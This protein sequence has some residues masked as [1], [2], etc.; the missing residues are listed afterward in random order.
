M[1]S[2]TE[3]YPLSLH[4]ALPICYAKR[5]VSVYKKG[6]LL[7]LEQVFSSTSW[8]QAV[9][10]AKYLSII[11]D[12]DRKTQKKINALIINISQKKLDREVAVRDRK[13]TRL[14]SRHIP[15]YRMPSSA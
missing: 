7:P 15:L 10:R 5:V 14:N 12:I 8:R 1:P 6:T 2:T 13:S 11:S 3:I 4:A 9:Y